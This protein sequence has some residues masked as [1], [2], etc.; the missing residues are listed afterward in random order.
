M[1]L[2]TTDMLGQRVDKVQRSIDRIKAFAPPDGYHL[3]FSGGKDSVAILALAKMAGVAYKANYN[4]TTVD[5]P[6]LVKFIREKYPSV[7]LTR[8]KRSMRQLII[9]KHMPPTRWHRYCCAELKESSGEGHVVMTGTRWAE[10]VRRRANQGLVTIFSG[11]AGRTAAKETGAEH[12]ITRSG[13][14]VMNMDND[15]SRRTVE[16]CYRTNRT[17]INPIIDWTDEDVWEF[18]RSENIPYCQLYDEG[19]KRLGCIGCPL[20]G[21]KQ[22][23]KEFERWPV[24]YRVYLHAFADMLDARRN[25]GKPNTLWPDAEAVMQWWL[26]EPPG[27]SQ[28][29]EG[30]LVLKDVETR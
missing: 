3:A 27:N 13:G 5:P 10:S 30:Q 18:I 2:I 12:R 8:P 9:A 26:R 22:Q 19:W 14:I 7:I 11:K 16:L 1:P 15:P 20:A 25:A 29:V 21:C 6:E 24:Y 28:P 4:I 23:K 17:L